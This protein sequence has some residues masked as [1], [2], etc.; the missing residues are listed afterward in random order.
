MF[1]IFTYPLAFF[2]L[3]ALPVLVAIYW[4]RQRHRRFP[5]S[6]LMLWLDTPE[7]REGGTRLERLQTPLLFFLELLALL[8]L[9]LAA[10]GPYLP[11]ATGARPLVVV[12]D[13]SFSMEAGDPDSPRQRAMQAIEEELRR[14]GRSSVRFLV[15]GEKTEA[16]GEPVR[17]VSEAMEQLRGWK[18]HAPVSHLEEALSL[19]AELGGEWALLLVVTDHPPAVDL[20]KGRVQWWAFGRALPNL[21]IVNAARTVREGA[22]RCLF[23]IANL[24]EERQVTS[25]V[26]ETGEPPVE[27]RRSTL[28]LEPREIHRLVLQLPEGAGVLRARLGEDALAIDNQVILQP[29]RLRPVRLALD[30]HD[31]ALRKLSEKAFQAIR[32][33]QI[34]D[35]N[36]DL[37][38]TDQE[39][40][41]TVGPDTWVVQFLVEKEAEAYTGPFVLDRAHPLTEGLSLPGVIWGAGKSEELPGSPVILAGNVP[42][43]S[44]AVGGTGR[45]EVRWRWRPDLSTLQDTPNWPI[46]MWNLVEWRASY[47]PGLSRANVRL[48]EEATLTFASAKESAQVFDPARKTRTV[49]VQGKQ[50]V[51]KAGDVGIYEIQTDEGTASFAVNALSRDESDL[52][53]CAGGRW[54]DWLDETS[55]RLEYQSVVWLLLLLVLALLTGHLILVARKYGR[56]S[57]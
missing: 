50:L 29:V 34:T 10:A 16:L 9:A 47:L 7:A 53:T 26:I 56:R 8:L 51:V 39:P 27:L 12:L 21:A 32:D 25:F 22:D 6:S 36:L 30:I 35:T 4:L 42:L 3:L 14:R 33:I 48:G 11:N 37:L 2:G 31:E 38:V 24:S 5:V 15:A 13:D 19:A 40:P 17:T 43:L 20:D 57:A 49:P 23:E 46:L 45:H 55:L 28:Q 1:P 18:C 54:G 44:D 52:T 41:A